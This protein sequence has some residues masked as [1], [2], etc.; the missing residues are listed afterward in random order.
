M[1][2]PSHS[3]GLWWQH[4]TYSDDE[5]GP[6]HDLLSF[7]TVPGDQR[8]FG[9]SDYDKIS[10]LDDGRVTRVAKQKCSLNIA[11][12]KQISKISERFIANPKSVRT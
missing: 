10:Q 12:P 7:G 8:C 3:S 11:G 2:T 1:S 6:C 4:I 5:V 9:E